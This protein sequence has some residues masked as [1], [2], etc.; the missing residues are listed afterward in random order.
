V[1]FR[2][3]VSIANTAGLNFDPTRP[4]IIQILGATN[5]SNNITVAIS[6]VTANTITYENTSGVTESTTNAVLVISGNTYPIQSSPDGSVYNSTTGI[7]TITTLST[8]PHSLSV[9]NK[10][11]FDVAGL[12]ICTVTS[13]TG[14]TTFTVKGDAGSATKVYTV[15]LI[16]TVA[17]TNATNENLN[18]RE[19]VP[20]VGY[21][22]RLLQDITS[23]GTT[24]SVDSIKGLKKG[25]FIQ[26]DS[27][28]MLITKI[29]GGTLTVNRGVLGTLAT[30]HL[31]YKLVKTVSVLPVELR[32]P[33]KSIWT[34]F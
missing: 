14:I 5:S 21:T 1:L 9:G 30:S 3:T 2:S 25:D 27:E 28:T 17:D 26:I 6:S 11:T 15:G 16:P 32:R 22:T 7:T 4:T 19:F 10:V 24:F 20:Y 8:Y 29:S 33:S 23:S 31:I 18:I 34:Y 12:G 13:V